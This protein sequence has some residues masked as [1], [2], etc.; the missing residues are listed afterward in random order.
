[1]TY[2]NITCHFEMNILI[3]V[4]W[5]GTIMNFNFNKIYDWRGILPNAIT[6]LFCLFSATEDKN[7]NSVSFKNEDWSDAANLTSFDIFFII[8]YFILLVSY[9]RTQWVTLSKPAY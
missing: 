9:T 6:T 4:G 7:K 5:A 8:I 3:T 1:M 2:L